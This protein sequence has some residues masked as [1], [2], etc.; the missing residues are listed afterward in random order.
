MVLWSQSYIQ[1]ACIGLL[2]GIWKE[3]PPSLTQKMSAM[4]VIDEV[5]D[6]GTLMRKPM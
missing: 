3:K 6:T 1:T 4:T 2:L 5:R